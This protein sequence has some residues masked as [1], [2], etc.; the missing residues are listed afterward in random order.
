MRQKNTVSYE[1]HNQFGQTKEQIKTATKEGSW[2]QGKDKNEGQSEF[3][4][5]KTTGKNIVSK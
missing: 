4:V 1:N 2:K 5:E 3:R